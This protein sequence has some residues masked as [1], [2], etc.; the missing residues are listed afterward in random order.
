MK[1]YH[2]AK[3]Q[4]LTLFQLQDMVHYQNLTE[5]RLGSLPFDWLKNLPKDEYTKAT[6]TVDKA[7]KEFAEEANKEQ[8][9]TLDGLYGELVGKL[10]KVLHRDDI[11]I[12][13]VDNGYWKECSKLTIGKFEYAFCTFFEKFGYMRGDDRAYGKYA[14]PQAIFFTYKKMPHGRMAKP[15]MSSFSTDY[16]EYGYT[17]NRFIDKNDTARAKTVL[18]PLRAEYLEYSIPD[19]LERS[20]NMINNI[21]IDPD[22]IVKN[23]NY[24][25]DANFRHNLDVFLDRIFIEHTRQNELWNEQKFNDIALV[26]RAE[27]FLSEQMD[28]GVDIFKADLRELLKPLDLEQQLYAKKLIR[29]FKN[30]HKLKN[31]LKAAGVYEQYKEIL[32]KYKSQCSSILLKEL[33]II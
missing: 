4:N 3:K 7:F 17:L 23:P 30:M 22:G 12:E 11:E 18:N 5:R 8:Y 31:N 16:F 19:T 14:A 21:I 26:R 2:V 6:K 28:K 20:E 33:E 24:V 9:E 27:N 10:K 25:A 32:S 13:Y 15:F 29:R 1:I